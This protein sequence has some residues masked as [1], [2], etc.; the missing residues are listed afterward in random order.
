MSFLVE[1]SIWIDCPREELFDALTT[2]AIFNSYMRGVSE[3]EFVDDNHE[4]GA[5][6]RFKVSMFGINARIVAEWTQYDPPSCIGFSNISGPVETTALTTLTAESGGTRLERVSR[7]SPR[8]PFGRIGAALGK[9]TVLK[10]QNDEFEM[11]RE[12]L[13]PKRSIS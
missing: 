13:G 9:R 11:L 1:S 4:L 5:R 3:A 8:G 2:P 6:I 10:N 12:L 7:I